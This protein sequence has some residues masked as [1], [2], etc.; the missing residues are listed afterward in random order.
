MT[1]PTL[2]ARGAAAPDLAKAG[3]VEG[4]GACKAEMF[5][6]VA[7]LHSFICHPLVVSCELIPSKTG[8]GPGWRETRYLISGAADCK[9]R[10]GWTLRFYQE[11]N[12][13]NSSIYSVFAHLVPLSLR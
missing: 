10:H 5:N 6:H 1:E 12:F 11:T 2:Q 7:I 4:I 8:S 13:I 3:D 9:T